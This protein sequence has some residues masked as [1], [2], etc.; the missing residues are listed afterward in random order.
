MP[1]QIMLIYGYGLFDFI[2]IFTKLTGLNILLM[3]TF[4]VAAYL[5]INM[6]KNIYLL[7][8]IINVLVLGNNYFVARYSEVFGSIECV[9]ASMIFIAISLTYYQHSIVDIFND[10]SARWWL[11]SPRQKLELP[12]TIKINE[13]SLTTKTYNLSETGLFM[14]ND[15]LFEV[16]KIHKNTEVD[17]TIHFDSKDIQLAGIVARRSLSRG[18]YPDGIGIKLIPDERYQ[19]G[20]LTYLNNLNYAA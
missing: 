6:N 7:I 17:M 13:R 3:I 8:P 1:L 16:F 9:F 18:G 4:L 10:I 12:I 14:L 11:S 19:Q 5:T 15:E 2:P 20:Y